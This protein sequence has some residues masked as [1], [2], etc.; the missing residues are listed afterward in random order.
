MWVSGVYEEQFRPEKF[1]IT[2]GTVVPVPREKVEG[3]FTKRINT[4]GYDVE[5]KNDIM[6]FF[7]RIPSCRG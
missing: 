1:K 6:T 3:W 2:D 7:L 4:G 5:P